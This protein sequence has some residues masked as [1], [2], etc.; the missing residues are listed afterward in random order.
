MV[1]S[2]HDGLSA[3]KRPITK[4][5]GENN[6]QGEYLNGYERQM[7]YGLIQ[8][9]YVSPNN[10]AH[11]VSSIRSEVMCSRKFCTVFYWSQLAQDWGSQ[12]VSQYDLKRPF[13]IVRFD[14][15][16]P[17]LE[18]APYLLFRKFLERSTVGFG[19]AGLEG[20]RMVQT[21][22]GSL[23][24]IQKGF[25]AKIISRGSEDYR[26]NLLLWAHPLRSLL[27]LRLLTISR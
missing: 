13:R 12:S 1:N 18:K 7:Q 2:L 15:Q 5:E 27:L 22:E 25:W 10:F 20:S 11:P 16:P 24:K 8:Q 23:D 9:Q 4:R 21:L 17:R 14:Q 3:I 19:R 26:V 6:F